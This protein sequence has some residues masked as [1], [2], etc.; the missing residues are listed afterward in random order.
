MNLTLLLLIMILSLVNSDC[1]E[2]FKIMCYLSSWTDIHPE[3]NNCTHIVYTLAQTEDNTEAL[4]SP[5]ASKNFGFFEHQ[6]RKKSTFS[7]T[8]SYSIYRRERFPC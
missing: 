7:E 8:Y 5:P 1:S 2:E 3:A 6:N 4:C